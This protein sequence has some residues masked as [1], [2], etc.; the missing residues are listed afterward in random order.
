MQ[1]CFQQSDLTQSPGLRRI[2][3]ITSWYEHGFPTKRLNPVA[4]T[5]MPWSL[6]TWLRRFQ[7][8]D[9]TQS[10]GRARVLERLRSTHASVSNKAT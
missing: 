4:G 2:S 10:P 8:S 9:L 6:S 1:K 7:Q 3:S 5:R